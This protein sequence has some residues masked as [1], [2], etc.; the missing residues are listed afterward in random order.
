MQITAQ[1]VEHRDDPEAMTI[2]KMVD[3]VLVLFFDSLFLL[4]WTPGACLFVCRCTC[5]SNKHI[6]VY[7]CAWR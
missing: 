4:N 1:S 7:L 3:S 6:L 2:T 5:D